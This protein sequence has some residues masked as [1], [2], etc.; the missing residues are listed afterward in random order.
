MTVSL[1]GGE[2]TL[3]PKMV[4]FCKKILSLKKTSVEILT[5]F[6]QPLDYYLDLLERGMKIAAT[7]HGKANDKANLEYAK[8]MLRVPMKYF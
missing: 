7:W 6:S 1:I 2:P 4:D 3:H 5:N 8:K